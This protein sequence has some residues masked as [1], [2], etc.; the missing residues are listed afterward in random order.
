MSNGHPLFRF[1]NREMGPIIK[2]QTQEWGKT[3][4]PFFYSMA[5]LSSQIAGSYRENDL[6]GFGGGGWSQSRLESQEKAI[7]E[8]IERWAFRFYTENHSNDCGLELDPTSNGFAALPVEL[9]EDRCFL[10]SACEAI[11]RYILCAIWEQKNVQLK[12]LHWQTA[13]G[14]GFRSVFAD[15]LDALALYEYSFLAHN[16]QKLFSQVG[17]NW[18]A[19]KFVLALRFQPG[20]GVVCGSACGID[21]Q[22]LPE[23]ATLEAFNHQRVLDAFKA[24]DLPPGATITDQ[25][26]LHFGRNRDAEL[27]VKETIDCNVGTTEALPRPEFTLVKKLQGPWL[28]EVVVTR[29]LVANSVPITEGNQWRFL[30]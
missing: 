16:E 27:R 21:S 12:P 6:L 22:A 3:I 28:P 7:T 20:G 10:H 30:I 17:I 19:I 2:L 1:L 14:V 25:R 5:Q 29:V 26:L 18:G 15:F 13:L 24:N 8:A 23:R 11:E 4:S 9:G